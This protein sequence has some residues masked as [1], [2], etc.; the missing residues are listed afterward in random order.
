[1]GAAILKTVQPFLESTPSDLHSKHPAKKNIAAAGIIEPTIPPMAKGEKA[2]T[3]NPKP[4]SAPIAVPINDA[5]IANIKVSLS[6]QP[7]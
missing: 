2:V 1:M 6:I 3:L 7:P 4:V 5:P